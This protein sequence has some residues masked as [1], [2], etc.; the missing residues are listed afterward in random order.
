MKNSMAISKQTYGSACKQDTHA[1]TGHIS[2]SSDVKIFYT[3]S[4]SQVQPLSCLHYFIIPRKQRT[5]CGVPARRMHNWSLKLQL[6]AVW[7][8]G[9]SHQG[10]E[11]F[12]SFF[13]N[14]TPVIQLTVSHFTDCIIHK[15]TRI[16]S[17]WKIY[18]LL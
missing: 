2:Q 10:I 4:Q 15:P 7:I 1:N 16:L 13:G 18:K 8:L 11:C 6:V 17:I 3:Q 5:L 9:G 12:S 14:W